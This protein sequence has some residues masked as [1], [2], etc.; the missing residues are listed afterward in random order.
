MA[1]ER[2]VKR[3]TVFGPAAVMALALAATMA[4]GGCDVDFERLQREAKQRQPADGSV[5]Q[6]GGLPDGG[7]LDGGADAGPDG[8]R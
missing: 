8:G 4:L 6:D 1:G 5:S 3:P 7:A 2:L